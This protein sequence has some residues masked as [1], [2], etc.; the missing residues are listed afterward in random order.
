MLIIKGSAKVTAILHS[1]SR[2][3]RG[4][5]DFISL[6]SMFIMHTHICFSMWTDAVFSVTG[7]QWT[8]A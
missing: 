1:I 8:T 6:R 7:Y 4:G 3:N 2:Y 5:H